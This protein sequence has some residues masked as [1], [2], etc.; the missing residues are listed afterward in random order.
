[1]AQL[2]TPLR[3]HVCMSDYLYTLFLLL[4]FVSLPPDSKS[5][6]NPIDTIVKR[7]QPT[8]SGGRKE[9]GHFQSYW[10]SIEEKKLAK[11]KCTY[12]DDILAILGRTKLVLSKI[13]RQAEGKE[14]LLFYPFFFNFTN[15]PF[16]SLRL[17]GYINCSNIPESIP[18]IFIVKCLSVCLSAPTFS[19]FSRDQSSRK[20]GCLKTN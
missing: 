10:P 3:V 15:K 18:I 14:N 16:F 1:M 6:K 12:T 5:N 13:Y 2:S 4:L 7:R 9:Q 19:S 20:M 8:K 11:R 17:H